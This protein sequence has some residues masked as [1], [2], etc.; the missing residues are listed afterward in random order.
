M[1]NLVTIDDI[2]AAER[3]IQ[4]WVERTPSIKS[5]GLGTKLGAQG[6]AFDARRAVDEPV[7]RALRRHDVVDGDEV[8]HDASRKEKGREPKPPPS[9]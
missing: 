8:V 2:A 3:T 7:D 9:I 1:Q 4:G 6:R 5:P